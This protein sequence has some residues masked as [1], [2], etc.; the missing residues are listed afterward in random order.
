MPEEFRMTKNRIDLNPDRLEQG[1]VLNPS[2]FSRWRVTRPRPAQLAACLTLLCEPDELASLSPETTHTL[3]HEALNGHLGRLWVI[4]ATDRPGEVLGAMVSSAHPGRIAFCWPPRL[5]APEDVLATELATTLLKCVAE[6]HA[7]DGANVMQCLVW[8][9]PAD[10][11]PP[12][13]PDWV[14]R[15]LHNAGFVHQTLLEGRECT[16]D[17]IVAASPSPLLEAYAPARHVE[18]ERLV[19][20]TLVDSCDCPYLVGKRSGQDL[21]DS[22]GPIDG[23][24][25]SWWWRAIDEGNGQ[26]AGVLLL[27]PSPD[28]DRL[29]IAYV[30]VVPEFRGR[31]WGRRLIA[32]A[33][34]R[35]R[36]AGK[37]RI[38]VVVD[39]SNVYAV[40]LY[41]QCGLAVE[42]RA[43]AYVWLA[44][45]ARPA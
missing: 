33:G 9:R 5:A 26:S 21:L 42:G 10:S 29:E 27:A 43:L 11:E 39:A 35:A 7:S 3:A 40:D 36:V 31:G 18:W 23:D 15:S 41:E 13:V 45:T 17:D 1:T 28:T 38:Q 24:L 16:V 30:G 25:T 14:V 44:E 32:A 4:T 2:A 19:A 8:D 22:L 20:A 34:E 37:H 12:A 6:S